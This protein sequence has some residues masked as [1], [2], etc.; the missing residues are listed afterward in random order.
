MT[1]VSV[2][3]R[4]LKYRTWERF[5][6][7]KV[8]ADIISITHNQKR[9]QSSNSTQVVLF[10]HVS[11]GHRYAN[12]VFY[13]IMFMRLYH[14]QNVFLYDDDFMDEIFQSKEMSLL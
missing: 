3:Q 8:L 10:F 13:K 7:E 5:V 12:I 9:F 11:T 4:G 14:M 1:L 2:L 6:K